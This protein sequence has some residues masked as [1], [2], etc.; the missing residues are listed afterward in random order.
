MFYQHTYSYMFPTREVI[1]GLALE[2]FKTHTRIAL[3][4]NGFSFLTHA[5]LTVSAVP[6]N[7]SL[8]TSNLIQI[9]VLGHK[10]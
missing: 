8:Y 3:T 5:V 10:V 4:G 6:F 7:G 9:C 2:Y 1:M